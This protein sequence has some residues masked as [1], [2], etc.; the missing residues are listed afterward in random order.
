[1]YELL[2]AF[3]AILSE[4]RSPD[5]RDN[6]QFI[7]FAAITPGVRS[8]AVRDGGGYD[9]EFDPGQWSERREGLVRGLAAA[10]GLAPVFVD[11]G[12]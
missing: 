6:N 5:S 12:D 8:I 9:V 4:E 1:M 10:Y 2:L 11:K 3:L 7:R